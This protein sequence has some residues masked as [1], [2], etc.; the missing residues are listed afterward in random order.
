MNSV[1]L[2]CS[3]NGDMRRE[4]HLFGSIDRQFDGTLGM[5]AK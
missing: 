2:Y 5:K 1:H 3:L 4:S